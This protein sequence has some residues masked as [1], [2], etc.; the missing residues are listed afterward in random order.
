MRRPLLPV[1]LLALTTLTGCPREATEVAQHTAALQWFDRYSS[2]Y[3]HTHIGV[4]LAVGAVGTL[5]VDYDRDPNRVIDARS[6]DPS[7]ARVIAVE[8]DRLRIEGVAEGEALVIIAAEK[9]DIRAAID[10]RAPAAISLGGSASGKVVLG[11]VEPFAAR[12][13]D[14]DD[15]PLT[16]EAPIELP[17]DPDGI[18]RQVPSPP[19]EVH[20][21]YD[22]LGVVELGE[23][24][25]VRRQV[26]DP[27]TVAGIS[28]S[29]ERDQVAVDATTHGL[30]RV[31]DEEGDTL[32]TGIGL[33]DIEALDPTICRAGPADDPRLSRSVVELTGLS[34]GRCVVRVTLGEHT[35]EDD[36]A[37][38]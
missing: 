33:V 30:T 37:V 16:G 38:R 9:G 21:R 24:W 36:I 2:Q 25:P 10:V 20:L 28:L 26:V 3:D 35:A 14:I 1:A 34:P 15:A 31:V 17:L 23:L 19:G 5:L 18:A 7:V 12:Q 13:Y 6:D 29:F 27:D 11:A 32:T 4:P 22:A 8:D